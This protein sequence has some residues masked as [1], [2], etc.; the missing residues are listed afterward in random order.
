M[1]YNIVRKWFYTWLYFFLVLLQG[2]I[3]RWER[4]SGRWSWARVKERERERV[5]ERDKKGR[6]QDE[7]ELIQLRKWV[8]EWK[9]VDLSCTTESEKSLKMMGHGVHTAPWESCSK[10]TFMWWETLLLLLWWLCCPPPPKKKIY[11]L[12]VIVPLLKCSKC[13]ESK[14]LRGFLNISFVPASSV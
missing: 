10:C 11:F 8:W 4:P 2:W 5:R 12:A 9:A 13:C 7:R 3:R 14:L 6:K 1:I